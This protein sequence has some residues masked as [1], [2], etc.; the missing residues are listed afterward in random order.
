[1]LEGNWVRE[2][3]QNV[4]AVRMVSKLHS[5]LVL[6]SPSP[7]CAAAAASTAFAFDPAHCI[8]S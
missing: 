3:L 6:R 4:S 8:V 1:M 5:L 2:V 7:G